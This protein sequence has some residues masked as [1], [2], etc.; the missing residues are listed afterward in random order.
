[1]E[2][3]RSAGHNV[4]EDKVYA[5]IFI[6]GDKNTSFSRPKEDADERQYPKA[7]ESFDKGKEVDEDGIS[8][9]MLP[10]ISPSTQM[11]LNATGIYTVEDLAELNDSVVIGV[12]GMVDLR[13]RAQAY[14]AAL[15]PP[16]EKPKRTRRKRNPETGELE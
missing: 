10:S 7:W 8:L 14:L 11:N 4:Y 6:K 3:T 2:Q 13:K 12:Q 5:E 9:K 15:N 1:V 16:E